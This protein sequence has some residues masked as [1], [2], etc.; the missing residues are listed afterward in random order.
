MIQR[1]RPEETG[2]KLE[3]NSR[4]PMSLPTRP[5]PQTMGREKRLALQQE[6][7]SLL[8]KGAIEP[9]RDRQA[10]F[11]SNLFVVKKQD[12]GFRPVINLKGLNLFIKKRS[13]RMSL[14]RPFVP[15]SDVKQ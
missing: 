14:K 3:F 9:V 8:R 2:W 15:K 7:L 4:P 11:Y 1:D 12:G 5:P 13:F 10:G 6:V